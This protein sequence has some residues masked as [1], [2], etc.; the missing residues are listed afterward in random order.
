MSSCFLVQNLKKKIDPPTL[1]PTKPAD[2]DVYYGDALN[3]L[4]IEL[5]IGSTEATGY[6]W[7]L[8][9]VAITNATDAIYTLTDL[10]VG[11]YQYYCIVSNEGGETRS[12]TATIKISDPKIHYSYDG[13]HTEIEDEDGNWRIKFLSS[14]TLTFTSFGKF[15][16]T[17]DIFLVGGGG[18]GGTNADAYVHGGGG[19]GG[20]TTTV[21]QMALSAD[22]PFPVIVGAGGT[23]SGGA[24]GTSSFQI[25]VEQSSSQAISLQNSPDISLYIPETTSTI[26]TAAGGKGGTGT[27]GGDGGS[28]GGGG[29]QTRKNNTD[30]KRNGIGG[31]GGSDGKSGNGGTLTISGYAWYYGGNGQNTTTREFGEAT[32]DLYSGG[33]GGGGHNGG[34]A[35]GAGGGGKSNPYSV[36]GEAGTPNTGGGGG[37]GRAGGGAGGSGIVIIRNHRR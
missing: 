23:S 21:T 25:G 28:G 19:G 5:A 12:R 8:N 1:N 4:E 35:G 33:G 30:T 27:T 3:A 6:Q 29:T 36:P 2:Q 24:G 32:G 15:G 20:Y 11:T 13:E 26:Y 22:T 10:A 7:F 17:V 31:D 18:A 34:G 9:D 37:Q 14:G 16:N